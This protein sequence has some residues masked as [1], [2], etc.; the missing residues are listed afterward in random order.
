MSTTCIKQQSNIL[1]LVQR[2]RSCLVIKRVKVG[3]GWG[4]VGGQ[5]AKGKA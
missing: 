2:S 5:G 4:G 1:I 3:E